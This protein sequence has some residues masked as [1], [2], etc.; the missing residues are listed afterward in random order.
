MRLLWPPKI[1]SVSYI[2]FIFLCSRLF[3]HF[4]FKAGRRLVQEPDGPLRQ[5]SSPSHPPTAAAQQQQR[6]G[7]SS[8]QLRHRLIGGILPRTMVA[9]SVPSTTRSASSSRAPNSN[10]EKRSTSALSPSNSSS[11]LDLGWAASCTVQISFASFLS[12]FLDI[13]FAD[14]RHCIVQCFQPITYDL[15]NGTGRDSRCGSV[16]RVK[17][18]TPANAQL[19]ANLKINLQ[20]DGV[21]INIASWRV[22]FGLLK[23]LRF[24]GSTR[25]ALWTLMYKSRQFRPSPQSQL[26]VEKAVA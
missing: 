4:Q 25:L 21:R 7:S 12:L 20:I 26:T 3:Y 14:V 10:T 17:D 5:F 22:Q 1:K 23:I 18:F 6:P 15:C 8:G 9:T 19:S 11:T 2:S 13:C 16:P 24:C